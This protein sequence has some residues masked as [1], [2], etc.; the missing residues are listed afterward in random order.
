MSSS[1]IG[2]DSGRHSILVFGCQRFSEAG[3]RGTCWH[4]ERLQSCQVKLSIICITSLCSSHSDLQSCQV[5]SFVSHLYAALHLSLCPGNPNIVFNVAPVCVHLRPC[6]SQNNHHR[7]P[8]N[9]VRR[10]TRAHPCP[11]RCRV[12]FLAK[13]VV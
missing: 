9:T 2:T 12:L 7:L 4:S 10:S 6:L 1:R 11:P 3:R 8:K 13:A 5:K